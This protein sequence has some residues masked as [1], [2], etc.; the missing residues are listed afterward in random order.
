[1]SFT[2]QQGRNV[3]HV[4]NVHLMER[5]T[6]AALGDYGD[7]LT[8][9]M[10]CAGREEGGVDTCLVSSITPAWRCT[11]SNIMHCFEQRQT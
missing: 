2:V 11:I 3:L 7:K 10:L 1:M 5:T 9:N 6:C 4:A 8:E